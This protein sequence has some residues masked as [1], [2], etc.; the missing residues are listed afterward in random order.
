MF[1]TV[2]PDVTD[3]VVHLSICC[4]LLD[5]LPS[6]ALASNRMHC[7]RHTVWVYKCR[8]GREGGGGGGATSMNS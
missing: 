1:V 3:S 6:F 2:K 4:A 5:M 8:L 7:D